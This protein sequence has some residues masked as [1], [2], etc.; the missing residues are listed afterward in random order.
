MITYGS[1]CTVAFNKKKKSKWKFVFRDMD[2]FYIYINIIVE[3]HCGFIDSGW[4]F[5]TMG[6]IGIWLFDATE[7][8]IVIGTSVLDSE[9][10]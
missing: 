6:L 4:E 10:Y 1:A 2:N 9:K 5:L 8:S 7:L 3:T